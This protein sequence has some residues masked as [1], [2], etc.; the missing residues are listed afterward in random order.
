MSGEGEIQLPAVVRQ[1]VLREFQAGTLSEEQALA[2]LAAL[3]E[4][5]PETP[6]SAANL[7]PRGYKDAP[8]PSIKIDG[9]NQRSL[10]HMAAMEDH[11]KLSGLTTDAGRILIFASRTEGHALRWYQAHKQRLQDLTWEEFKAEYLKTFPPRGR[12]EAARQVL[13]TLVFSGHTMEKFNNFVFKLQGAL[14][15]LPEGEYTEA[16]LVQLVRRAVSG[17]ELYLQKLVE[18]KP[19]TLDAALEVLSDAVLVA[20]ETRA[21]ER[22]HQRQPQRGGGHSNRGKR[23]PYQDA[24][25]VEVNAL[26]SQ[27]GKTRGRGGRGQNRWRGRRGGGREGG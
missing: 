17:T 27:S 26:E 6:K 7:L 20:E 5:Q 22:L 12:A 21:A 10:D 14:M 18:K 23:N 24:G 8:P 25:R 15:D 3:S 19:L 1:S 16:G 13:A 9:S 2:R 4:P 11:F